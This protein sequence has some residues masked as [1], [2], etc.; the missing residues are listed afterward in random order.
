MISFDAEQNDRL[1]PERRGEVADSR[2]VTDICHR[3]AQNRPRD[4]RSGVS[5]TIARP[6]QR[7]RTVPRPPSESA[8]P[9]AVQ[10]DGER[11]QQLASLSGRRRIRPSPRA[12]LGR[13]RRDGRPEALCGRPSPTAGARA[14]LRRR[15]RALRKPARAA[16]DPGTRRPCSQVAPHLL[17]V[18]A[19]TG[20]HR[21]GTR[22]AS[23]RAK[24]GPGRRTTR[25]DASPRESRTAHARAIRPGSPRWVGSSN[26]AASPS[27]S[28][29]MTIDDAER[30][31]GDGDPRLRSGEP[32]RRRASA[33]LAAGAPGS[34]G[35]R[36]PARRDG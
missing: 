11:R 1:D 24:C 21:S 14:D 13:R 8:G 16:L 20:D 34:P 5:S 32:A 30:R 19:T 15:A 6:G 28:K 2:V 4:G 26:S 10:R 29:S 9:P 35:G 12:F 36:R 18:G 25:P 3:N 27:A 31:S 7:R 22:A 23:L 33:R 17:T